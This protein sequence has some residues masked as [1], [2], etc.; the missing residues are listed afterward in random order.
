M[1]TLDRQVRQGWMKGMLL[2]VAMVLAH[3]AWAATGTVLQGSTLYPRV[4]RLAHGPAN[5]NGRLI[6]STNGIIFQSND[7]G[8]SW[9]RLGPVPTVGG[10][11]ERCCATLYELPRAVGS[12]AAGTLL[13]AASYFSGGVPAIEVYVSTDQG[14]H[15][16]YHGTPVRAGDASHG[17]WE[18]EFEVA[19]DGAL[20]MFWSDE[21]DPCCSQKLAQIRSYDGL[22]WQDRADTVRSTIPNDRPGMITVSPLP[23]GHFFMSYELCGPAACT[24]FSRVSV[25]GWYFGDPTNMGTR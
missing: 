7:D 23:N 16:T 19:N 24:V 12:L 4:V 20:V 13:S 9:S 21:T 3:G 18:P 6:A 10:S 2:L 17:L 14:A 1:R 8:A 15:W 11:S 5:V 22:H 25:D